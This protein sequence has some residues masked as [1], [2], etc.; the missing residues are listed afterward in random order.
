MANPFKSIEREIKKGINRLGDQVKSGINKLGNEVESGVKKVGHEVESGVK[1]AGN[2]VKHEVESVGKNAV[3][4]VEA[5]GKKSINELESEFKK[6]THEIEDV[7]EKAIDELEGEAK[8][9][10]NAIFAE[11]TS[12]GFHRALKV[13][14]KAE[15]IGE[16]ALKDASFSFD[17][18]AIGFAWNNIGGRVGEIRGKIDDL[19][20]K[21]PKLSRA[22]I[23]ECV[24]AL[25]PDT[26]SLSLDVKLAALIVTSDDVGVGFG[27]SISTPAFLEASDE[28]LDAMGL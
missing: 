17:V 18:S 21:T 5:L 22:Y 14:E 27:F 13:L 24:N 19:A 1:N 7:A 3:H 25:A 23:I 4:E 10:L 6:A 26:I 12:Q 28:L 8:A 15:R 9:V 16:T 11:L 20:K 2:T